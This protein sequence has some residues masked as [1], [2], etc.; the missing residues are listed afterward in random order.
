MPI[1]AFRYL[2]TAI[3]KD[4]LEIL[5][6]AGGVWTTV[7]YRYI[8][9]CAGRGVILR[10]RTTII[11]CRNVAIGA[12]SIFQDHVYIRAGADGSVRFGPRCMV[13]SFCRFFGHGGIEIGEASQF[14]PGVTVTTT[15]H[16]FT[17]DRLEETFRKVIIGRHVWIGANSTIL[18]GVTIGDRC[19]VGAGSV[20]TRD[21]PPNSVA[22]GAPARVIRSVDD[23]G[24][25]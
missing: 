23:P 9:R 13:N 25:R 7:K 10:S 19:V 22:V 2:L 11:N 6:I 16:D 5:D 17:S 14:G 8:R 3:R 15:N 21:L 12:G 24:G 1:N 18:P 20:V 4:P